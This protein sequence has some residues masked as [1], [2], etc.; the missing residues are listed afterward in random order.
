MQE[1]KWQIEGDLISKEEK[2][3]VLEDKELRVEIIWLHY[4]VLVA[5][6]RGRWK[7]KKLVM[8]NYWWPRLM[9]DIEKYV[10]SCN[11]Y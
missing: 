10:N 3:Y 5:G 4:N 2:I 1:N 6:H 9:R 11:I 7:M 8:R